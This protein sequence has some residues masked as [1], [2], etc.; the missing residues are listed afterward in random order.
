MS[1]L[2]T[3][4]AATCTSRRSSRRPV[5]LTDKQRKLL[6][7]FDATPAPSDKT[8]PESEGFFAKVKELWQD[9]RE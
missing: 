1:V 9:L 4:R 3:R 6:Q 2:R 7:E 5:N 8:S